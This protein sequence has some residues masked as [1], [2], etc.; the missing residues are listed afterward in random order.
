NWLCQCLF[1]EA[2][3][4]T[5]I[6]SQDC[7]ILFSSAYTPYLPD[8]NHLHGRLK[9]FYRSIQ[10]L[11]VQNKPPYQALAENNC[12]PTY[13][14]CPQKNEAL[15][16]HQTNRPVSLTNV[17]N[18]LGLRIYTHTKSRTYPPPKILRKHHRLFHL[19]TPLSFFL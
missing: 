10:I 9:I 12:S 13:R 4:Q 14:D 3:H 16:L 15:H 18:P 11:S 1:V 17:N 19:E 6:D 7:E 2:V 8:L 5:T